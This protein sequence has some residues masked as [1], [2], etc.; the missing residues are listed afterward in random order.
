M[1][2]QKL[3]T[4]RSQAAREILRKENI[5]AVIS[6][7][8]PVTSHLIGGELKAEHEIPWIADIRDLWSQNHNYRYSPL[9]RA[10]DRRLELK[11]L[12]KA[13]ALVTVSEPWAEKLR[14]LHK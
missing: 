1:P 6:S 7:S 9:R 5:A 12:S 13:D 2:R 10:L 3:E 14:N 4:F 8:P 11:T